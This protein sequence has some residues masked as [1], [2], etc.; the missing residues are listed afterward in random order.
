MHRSI[1]FSKGKNSSSF[2]LQE[3]YS[4]SNIVNIED[5]IRQGESCKM[6]VFQKRDNK[7]KNKCHYGCQYA[8]KTICLI[9]IINY[10]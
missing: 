10:I 6:S 8:Q 1:L 9:K 3:N 2:C 7:E 4:L 5:I